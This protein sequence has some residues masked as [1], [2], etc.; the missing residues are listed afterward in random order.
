MAIELLTSFS[1]PNSLPYL[2]GIGGTNSGASATTS[3]PA[4]LKTQVEKLGLGSV[5][6]AHIALSGSAGYSATPYHR[7][8]NYDGRGWLV[9]S[10]TE[11]SKHNGIKILFDAQYIAAEHQKTGTVASF[12]FRLGRINA[13]VIPA[14]GDRTPVFTI[15]TTTN[16]NTSSLPFDHEAPTDAYYEFVLRYTSDTNMTLTFYRNRVVV[17]TREN[18]TSAS[19]TVTPSGISGLSHTSGTK[20]VTDASNTNGITDLYLSLDSANDDPSTHTG[21]IGPIKVY[22]QAPKVLKPTGSWG[23]TDAT[24]TDFITSAGADGDTLKGFLERPNH[25]MPSNGHIISTASAILHGP[26]AS[27]DITNPP[28]RPLAADLDILVTDAGG[29]MLEVEFE[30]VAEG[31]IVRAQQFVVRGKQLASQAGEVVVQS[32]NANN[33]TVGEVVATSLPYTL[34]G[35]GLVHLPVVTKKANGSDIDA[36]Y[37]NNLKLNVGSRAITVEP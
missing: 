27:S 25:F 23:R 3:T 29:G 37:V 10:K 30:P 17:Y 2:Y 13:G 12:G 15:S 26:N 24:G 35:T 9:T 31:A 7:I 11:S 34:Y 16:T 28:E 5:E 36:E 32:V 14:S 8:V 1:E 22:R 20:N 18:C 6:R 4:L 33:D 21:M 19:L